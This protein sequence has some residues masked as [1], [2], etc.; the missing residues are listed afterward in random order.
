MSRTVHLQAVAPGFFLSVNMVA[1]QPLNWRVIKRIGDHLGMFGQ[2]GVNGAAQVADSFAVDEA[3][4]K[5]ALFLAGGEIVEDEVLYLAWL[6][7]MQ[8]QHTVDG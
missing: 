2:E 4:L 8:I 5:N 3:D 1:P 7:R 6:E